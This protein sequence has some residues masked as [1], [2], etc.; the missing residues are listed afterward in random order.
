MSK[1]RTPQV[2]VNDVC[3]KFGNNVAGKAKIEWTM[4]RMPVLEMIRTRYNL[5]RR[6]FTDLTIGA[7]L[8]VTAET[9]ALMITLKEGGAKVFLCASNPLSTNDDVATALVKHY[10]ISVFAKHGESQ[11]VYYRHLRQVLDQHP[12]ITMDDGADLIS[13]LHKERP[14]QIAEIIGS[15]EE[16]TTGV[17]RLKNM[18]KDG[19]LKLPVVAVNESKTK[20]LFDNRYG[21][22]Q[23]VIDGILR[24]TNI[25]LAGKTFVICGYGWCGK[26]VAMRAKGMGAKIIVCEVDPIKAL[27]AVMDGFE[28]MPI[29]DAAA[30]G[31]VFVTVT[32]NKNVIDSVAIESLKSG[33][34]LANAG[35]FD[36]EINIDY[37]KQHSLEVK[38]INRNLTSYLMK[39][40]DG[41]D[42][43]VHVLSEGRLVNLAAADG[44]PAEVMDMSFANQALAAEWLLTNETL[45]LQNVHSLPEELDKEVAKLKLLAMNVKIDRLTTEQEAYLMGWKEGT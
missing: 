43:L 23:S 33:A 19:A 17:L 44:H 32:G 34:I 21:T 22:G 5:Q 1:D 27:E 10:G 36:V 42:Y 38:E 16:T 11:E 26:G 29:D 2:V 24:A 30:K 15:S 14:D 9:A 40:D 28:V 45:L 25:L 8:H 3:W 6:P 13:L 7:C 12:K 41:R 35:H 20:H 4:A 18:E 37:L 39:R 31:D